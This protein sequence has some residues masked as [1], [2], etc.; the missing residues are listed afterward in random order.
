VSVRAAIMMDAPRVNTQVRP[1][2]FS[3]CTIRL[4]ESFFMVVRK[5]AEMTS[6]EPQYH[7]KLEDGLE[8]TGLPD[9]LKD[10]ISQNLEQHPKKVDAF[11]KLNRRIALVITDADIELTLRFSKGNLA[12]HAG[13]DADA[14][15]V[16]W[17]E[18]DV[19]MALSNQKM[20]FGLP[21]YFDDTGQEIMAAMKAG[22]L[23]VKG[24]FTHFPSMLRFSRVMSV[25]R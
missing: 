5:M 21:Y 25:T 2:I 19:I 15:I 10:L 14:A 13:L 20:K 11:C 16:I 1:Y 18:S 12:I 17:S 9:M 24:L 3:L 6:S 8:S 23:K 22:R 7:I 4:L